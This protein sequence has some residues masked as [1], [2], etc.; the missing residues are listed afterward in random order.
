MIGLEGRA[1]AL[2]LCLILLITVRAEDPVHSAFSGLMCA[3]ALAA[4][5]LLTTSVL[6]MS[7]LL[8]FKALHYLSGSLKLAH[9]IDLSLNYKASLYHLTLYILSGKAYYERSPLFAY[10]NLALMLI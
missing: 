10:V 7:P 8:A 1:L 6:A 3:S 9:F 4:L 2:L 5:Y